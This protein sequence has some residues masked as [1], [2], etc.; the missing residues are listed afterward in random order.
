MYRASY[1][2]IHARQPVLKQA[3]YAV[4][5]NW[6]SGKYPI[7]VVRRYLFVVRL[8]RRRG[9]DLDQFT[10]SSLDRDED[11]DIY[12]LADICDLVLSTLPPARPESCV[13]RVKHIVCLHGLKQL[14]LGSGNGVCLRP[15]DDV[16]SERIE[17]ASTIEF[18]I[19]VLLAPYVL[20]TGHHSARAMWVHASVCM[21][22]PHAIEH[23]RRTRSAESSPTS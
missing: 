9:F 6:T 15:G 10:S 5:R 11:A 18:H 16:N 13:L 4:R 7:R 2:C 1:A 21:D 14:I 19:R 8:R 20:S 12:D 23:G 17:S 3:S 22:L